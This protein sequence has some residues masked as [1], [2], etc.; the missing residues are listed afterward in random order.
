MGCYN[1]Y[2]NWKSVFGYKWL[3]SA[4]SKYTD[5]FYACQISALLELHVAL[6]YC[7]QDILAPDFAD[8]QTIFACILSLYMDGADP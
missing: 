1:R 4:V 8:K 7:S 2:A 6:K 5:R 3:Y